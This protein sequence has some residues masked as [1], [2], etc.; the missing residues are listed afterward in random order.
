MFSHWTLIELFD[1]KELIWEID[2]ENKIPAKYLKQKSTLG[3]MFLLY[4][5]LF[6]NRGAYFEMNKYF[7]LCLELEAE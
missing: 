3:R 7:Y 6:H 1:A 2:I 5:I 4:N